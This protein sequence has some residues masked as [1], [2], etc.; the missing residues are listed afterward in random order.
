MKRL[1]V[2]LC[3]VGF[4]VALPL[5]HLAMANPPQG[6]TWICHVTNVEILKPGY[7]LKEGRL[8]YLP[9]EAEAVHMAHGDFYPYLAIDSH[10]GDYCKGYFKVAIPK[11]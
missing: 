2:V 5:L 3:V 7:V 11:K 8:I 9:G 10:V 6:R 4:I 1:I